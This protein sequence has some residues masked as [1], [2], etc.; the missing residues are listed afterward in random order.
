L[1]RHL[2]AGYTSVGALALQSPINV[3]LPPPHFAKLATTTTESDEADILDLSKALEKMTFDSPISPKEKIVEND[4]NVE[5][6]LKPVDGRVSSRS[7]Q[8]QDPSLDE[9]R[10]KVPHQK[11]EFLLEVEVA[12][13]YRKPSPSLYFE[14]SVGFLPKQIEDLTAPER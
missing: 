5:P 11:Q 7:S 9:S 3:E 4:G 14:A 13:T 12:D 1:F 6:N 2:P 10:S 8:Q